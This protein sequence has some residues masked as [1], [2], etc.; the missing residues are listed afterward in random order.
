M[1][2]ELKVEEDISTR[3]QV[4]Y[5]SLHNRASWVV[6]FTLQLIMKDIHK[7]THT[8]TLTHSLIHP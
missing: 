6:T 1:K 3:R 2:F 4:C 8:H 5:E 7:H